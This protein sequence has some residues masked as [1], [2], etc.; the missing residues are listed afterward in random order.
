MTPKPFSPKFFF[1]SHVF[2]FIHAQRPCFL[3]CRLPTATPRLQMLKCVPQRRHSLLPS[4]V[5]GSP[6]EGHPV[7]PFHGPRCLAFALL[8]EYSTLTSQLQTFL[9]L[10]DQTWIAPLLPLHVPMSAGIPP[11][12]RALARPSPDHRSFWLI[13]PSWHSVL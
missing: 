1:S 7:T 10:I 12:P 6:G 4:L 13:A 8:L 5:S 3:S 9:T 11:S 2:L